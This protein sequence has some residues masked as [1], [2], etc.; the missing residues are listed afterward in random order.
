MMKK[1]AVVV[2]NQKSGCGVLPMSCVKCVTMEPFPHEHN[3]DQNKKNVTAEPFPH[4]HNDLEPFPN[5]IKE[6]QQ[7]AY[8][9]D[10]SV[11]DEQCQVCKVKMVWAC[12]RAHN[13]QKIFDVGTVR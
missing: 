9:R 13:L 11:H 10:I 3:T 12:F 7:V 6:I 8:L 2:A 5:C 4:E 1:L